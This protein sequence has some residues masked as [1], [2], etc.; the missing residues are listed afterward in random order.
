MTRPAR[1][2]ALALVLA[3]AAG[4]STAYYAAMEKLGWAKRDILVNRV[5]EARDSQD[6]AKT[7]F[8]D[9]LEQLRSVVTVPGG[10]LETKYETLK[11]AYD[12][13]ATRADDVRA[14]IAAVQSAGGALWQE[15][16]GEIAA[17]KDARR[18]A[19]SQELYR[20]SQQRYERMLA[21]M[22][23]AEA[24]MTPVLDTMKDQV[25]FLKHNLNAKAVAAMQGA[26]TEIEGDVGTLVAEMEGSIAEADQ[27]ITQLERAA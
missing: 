14:R 15:W 26:L 12:D 25:L 5:Q 10:D 8:T 6:Q 20:D 17:M 11:T 7:Q 21:A 3:G 23:R 27:Y 24:S 18:R 4:C 16:N 1:L 9:A 19:R 22:Q 13:S 2:A